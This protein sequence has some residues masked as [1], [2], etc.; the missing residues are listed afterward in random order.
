MAGNF[1]TVPILDYTL[2][3]QS[4]ERREEF[5][6]QLRN[7]LIN[8][9]FLYLANPPVDKDVVDSLLSFVPRLFDIPQEKKDAIKMENS[10]HFLGYTRLGSELTKGR[11]DQREQF[12]FATE[13]ECRWRPGD[14]EYRKLHGEAQVGASASVYINRPL[15]VHTVVI[16]LLTFLRLF[17]GRMRMQFPDSRQQC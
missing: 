8:V 6:L 16:P 5:V 17:S 7:A 2:L 1:T 14:P 13:Y 11:T 4:A 9:G 3:S 10:K 15:L 12:D